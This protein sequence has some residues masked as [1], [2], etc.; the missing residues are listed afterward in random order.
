[1]P[2]SRDAINFL[3]T[4]WLFSSALAS[5]NNSTASNPFLIFYSV[6]FDHFLEGFNPTPK[7]NS[8][9]KVSPPF[10]F[11]IS[12]PPQEAFFSNFSTALISTFDS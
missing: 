3:D 1:M 6:G 8:A 9:A 4:A 5:L 11:L 12:E 10:T 2:F 7:D